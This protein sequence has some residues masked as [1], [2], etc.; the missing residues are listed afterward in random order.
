MMVPD[1]VDP[2][3]NRDNVKAYLGLVTS[4]LKEKFSDNW[5]KLIPYVN[6]TISAESKFDP[7]DEKHV[8]R[9]GRGTGFFQLSDAMFGVLDKEL[10]L[11]GRLVNDHELGNDPETAARITA[12]LMYDYVYGRFDEKGHMVEGP[13]LAALVDDNKEIQATLNPQSARDSY[14]EW[15]Q[16]PNDLNKTNLKSNALVKARSAQYGWHPGQVLKFPNGLHA[17]LPALDFDVKYQRLIHDVQDSSK[18]LQDASHDWREGYEISGDSAFAKKV[19][20]LNEQYDDELKKQM[21][22][23]PDTKLSEVKLSSLT[24]SQ[25][26]YLMNAQR[27]YASHMEETLRLRH[28]EVTKPNKK[29]RY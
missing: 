12:Q 27:I 9:A 29:V 23:H 19:Q 4:K 13:S 28:E 24:P 14:L 7:V 18:T 1:A 22:L 21:G 2:V 15:L 17:F 3:K 10:G 6:A 5:Q 20:L 11:Q 25:L 8:S 16:N 26:R